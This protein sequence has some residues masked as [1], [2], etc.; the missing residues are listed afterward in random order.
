MVQKGAAIVNEGYRERLCNTAIKNGGSATKEVSAGIWKHQP[1]V[2]AS[3]AAF[4]LML[5]SF[6]A[7]FGCGPPVGYPRRSTGLRKSQSSRGSAFRTVTGRGVGP[8]CCAD[9]I[10]SIC[11]TGT[12]AATTVNSRANISRV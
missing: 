10:D 3:I 6:K 5:R 2:S 7:S 8:L 11:T 12:E 4:A 9:G 1:L